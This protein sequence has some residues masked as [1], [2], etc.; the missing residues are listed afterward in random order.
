MANERTLLSWVRTGINAIGVG[1]LL[2]TVVGALSG[3]SLARLL[4]GSAGGRLP[5][6][7][8]RPL[9]SHLG[10]LRRADRAGRGRPV[11]P[12]RMPDWPGRD[13]CR[14]DLREPSGRL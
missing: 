14:A 2:D 4:R 10:C 8:A 1:I 5:A 9:R 6:G 7:G 11:R 13:A 12:A 3:C